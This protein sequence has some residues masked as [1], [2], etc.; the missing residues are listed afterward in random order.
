MSDDE[1]GMSP[2]GSPPAYDAGDD[3]TMPKGVKKTVNTAG[4]G[5]EKPKNMYE[6]KVNIKGKHGENVF[7]SNEADGQP[8]TYVVGSGLPCKGLN[9]A[10]R[11]MKKGEKAT[12]VL[13]SEEAFG[14]EGLPDKNV[15]ADAEV[16]YEV[17]LVDWNKVEDI[18][19][20]KDKSILVKTLVEGPEWDKPKDNDISFLRYRGKVQVNSLIVSACLLLTKP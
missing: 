17:E 19:K 6:V 11:E 18:S 1:M 9:A 16:T 10:F 15:P 12:V 7:D 14:S 3:F 4:T 20:K 2:P 5:W 8:R 13:Q